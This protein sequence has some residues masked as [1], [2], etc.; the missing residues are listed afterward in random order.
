MIAEVNFRG[1]MH[2][3]PMS[4]KDRDAMGPGYKTSSQSSVATCQ[5]AGHS[6]SFCK[7]TYCLSLVSF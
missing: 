4:T 2:N 6:V 3:F 1:F 5:F 7:F